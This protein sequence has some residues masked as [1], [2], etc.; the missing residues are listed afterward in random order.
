MIFYFLFRHENGDCIFWWTRPQTT[1]K[2]LT[3]FST[4]TYFQEKDSFDEGS[5][6]SNLKT[7]CEKSNV[8]F[9]QIYSDEECFHVRKIDVSTQNGILYI[10]GNA[11]NVLII[12]LEK[13]KYQNGIVKVDL[14]FLF[15]FELTIIRLRITF[16][17]YLNF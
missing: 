11:G 6:F 8:G 2:L 13:Y 15:I 9:F 5:S 12:N 14:Q 4:S 7:T 16:F 1:F 17:I 3:K 10:G